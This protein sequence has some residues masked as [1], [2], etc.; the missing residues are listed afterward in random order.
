MSHHVSSM[1]II[2]SSASNDHSTTKNEDKENTK[3]DTKHH[4]IAFKSVAMK[5][6]VAV[7]LIGFVIDLQGSILTENNR[8]KAENKALHDKNNSL[9]TK[10]EVLEIEVALA[11]QMMWGNM[12]GRAKRLGLV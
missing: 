7:L 1:N 12:T 3:N 9:R 10:N 8:L 2:D 6:I 11:W 5:F 4:R